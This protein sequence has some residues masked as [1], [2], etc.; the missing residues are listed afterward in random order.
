MEAIKTLTCHSER[1]EE[2]L[3][4]NLKN[5]AVLKRLISSSSCFFKEHLLFLLK[6]KVTKS[7]SEFDAQHAL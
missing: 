5:D 4:N 1:S 6:E 7:S 2:S 3:V